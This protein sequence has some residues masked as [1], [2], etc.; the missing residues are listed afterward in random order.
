MPC[1]HVNVTPLL[2][3]LLWQRALDRYFAIL[4]TSSLLHSY[5]IFSRNKDILSPNVVSLAN[6]THQAQKRTPLGRY[7]LP[8][9]MNKYF[10]GLL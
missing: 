3:L 10:L 5:P 4:S 9:S 1:A 2:V 7:K 8:Y 6:T